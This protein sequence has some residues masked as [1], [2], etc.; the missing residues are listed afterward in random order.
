MP[1]LDVFK[2]DAF[3]SMSLTASINKL[4]FVPGLI[5]KMGIFKPKGIRTTTAFMEEKGGTLKFIPNGRRG[6]PASLH[7]SGKR[8][9]RSVPMPHLVLEDEILADDVQNI[10]AFGSET[11]LEAVAAVVNDHLEEM[12]LNHQSTLE[13]Y[14]VQALHG[15]VLDSDASTELVDL[16]DMFGVTESTVNFNFGTDDIREQITD[17][18]RVIETELGGL[19]FGGVQ[20]ICGNDWWDA[21]IGDSDV[22]TAFARWEDGRALRDDF[23]FTGFSFAGATFVNYR[24]SVGGQAFVASATARAFPLGTNGLFQELYAPADFMETVNTTGLPMYAK[25]LTLDFDRGIRLHTQSNPLPI[26]LKPKTLVKIT[27]S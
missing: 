2:G 17:V 20:F 6:G 21:F 8:T 9:A 3:S 23:R 7:N 18:L 12:K 26:C 14:R 25:Q 24:G 16:Y 4:P 19:G 10:R 22:A 1:N 27:K 11:E 15:K 5:G 13:W